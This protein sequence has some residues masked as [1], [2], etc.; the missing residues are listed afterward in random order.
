M[1]P[2]WLLYM[3]SARMSDFMFFKALLIL[4]MW[5]PN[6]D[7]NLEILSVLIGL[8]I[9]CLDSPLVVMLILGLVL[10]ELLIIL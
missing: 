1:R 10:P 6:K 8:I 4:A 7:I 2:L 9:Y 5:S 3:K